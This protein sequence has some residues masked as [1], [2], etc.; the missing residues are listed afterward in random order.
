MFIILAALDCIRLRLREMKSFARGESVL[1]ER[2]KKMR[3]WVF[4]FDFWLNQKYIIIAL[5]RQVPKQLSILYNV[6][7]PNL[8]SPMNKIKKKNL[9]RWRLVKKIK[10]II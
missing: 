5:I 6:P 8:I 2:G 9:V 3:M 1:L 10:Y 7:P 4:S